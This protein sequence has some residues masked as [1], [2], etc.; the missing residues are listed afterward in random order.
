MS[1]VP[2][3]LFAG[4]EDHAPLPNALYAFYQHTYG[5]A[6]ARADERLQAVLA[7]DEDA[8]AMDVSTGA[9]LIEVTRHAIDLSGRVVELRRSR[10]VTDDLA[11][12][13][14]LQ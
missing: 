9:P 13:V 7:T 2:S 4:L 3:E 11:Y 6:I 1:A 5:I 12:A 10:Y 8:A 14:T